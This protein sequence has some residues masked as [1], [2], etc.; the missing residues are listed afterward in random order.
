MYFFVLFSL[1][2]CLP[3]NYHTNAKTNQKINCN[4]KKNKK[5]RLTT[6]Y[7]QLQLQ[8]QISKLFS[9]QGHTKIL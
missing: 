4:L 8:P 2:N 7:A 6:A 1:L 5:T 9:S 3:I